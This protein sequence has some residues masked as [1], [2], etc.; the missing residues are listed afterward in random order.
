MDD[1]LKSENSKNIGKSI[2]LSLV[3]CCIGLMLAGGT[4]AYFTMAFNATNSNIVTD[5]RCF[6]I[7]Y[8][9]NTDQIT[10][11]LWPSAGPAKGL[12]G[13]IVYQ[14]N[15]SCG[16]SGRGTFKLMVA[17]G[18]SSTL[19][20]VVEPHCENKYTKETVRGFAQEDCGVNDSTEWVTNGTAL[21]YAIFDSTTRN[22][23]YAAGYIDSSFIGTEKTIHSNFSVTTTSK[24]YYIYIWLDGNLSGDDYANLPFSATSRLDVIQVASNPDPFTGDTY[25]EITNNFYDY[26]SFGDTYQRIQYLQSVDTQ[27]IDT[28]IKPTS[29]TDIEVTFKND[30]TNIAYQ[31]LFGQSN[32]AG[33]TRFQMQMNN[34]TATSWLVGVGGTNATVTVDATSDWKIVKMVSGEGLYVNDTLTSSFNRTE[35]NNY[36]IWLFRGYDKYSSLKIAGARIWQD[37]ELVRD[38]IPVSQI[39]GGAGGMF[40]LVNGGFYPNAGSGSFTLGNVCQNQSLSLPCGR[41]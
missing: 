34:T 3:I 10:G 38:L 20:G 30:G 32:S 29:T 35:A 25:T 15:T 18:T 2:I 23:I 5:T 13:S 17:N 4:Y 31:R 33:N 11:T 28:G 16:V 36:N 12:S 6:N 41:V 37:D 26:N 39:N 9:D 7:N 8:T 40:D 1:N 27:Y 14:A 22:H 19:T 21:K 24:T